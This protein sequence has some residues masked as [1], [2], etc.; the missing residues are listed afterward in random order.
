M[1]A[2]VATTITTLSTL[3]FEILTCIAEY[4]TPSDLITL[5][6]C[7]KTLFPLQYLDLLWKKHC[8]IEFGVDY[9]DPNQS[10]RELYATCRKIQKGESTQKRLPCNH[11]NTG[12]ISVSKPVI[13]ALEH[14]E[15][16]PKEG[17][18]SL[19]LCVSPHCYQTMCDR[20]S[21]QHARF[22]SDHS[23]HSIF[24][25]M[26]TS[27]LFCQVCV[28]WI[29]GVDSNPAEQ[30]IASIITTAIQERFRCNND[31][32]DYSIGLRLVRQFERQL[33]WQDTPRYIMNDEFCFISSRWMAD[34]EMF[35]EGWKTAPPGIIDQT[36]LL[37]S[38]VGLNRVGTNP[39]YLNSNDNVMVISNKAWQYLSK[40]YSVK[41]D[42]I[43]EADLKPVE[44]Y[45][46]I[47]KRIEYWKRRASDFTRGCGIGYS[48]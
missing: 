43:T 10:F 29:G 27:E 19:F 30:Y 36:Q 40:Q 31:L 20:H 23:Y 9:N 17:L 46:S 4:L 33:R 5:S 13:D 28:D 42:K 45:A 16:C 35:I 2:N 3:S 7:N 44:Q 24:Y 6:Q 26:N 18:E 47:I 39:F 14:C 32:R 37:A 1:A 25:K 48:C 41:G 11:I 22:S 38:V 21:R 15:R 34:W 8:R 12:M